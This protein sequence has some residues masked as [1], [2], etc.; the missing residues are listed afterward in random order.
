M[1]TNKI[2]VTVE[3]DTILFQTMKIAIEN[4]YKRSLNRKS[5]SD[6]VRIA[7]AEKVLNDCED[8]DD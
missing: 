8:K 2:R 3:F 7:V 1:T 5:I 4:D 6:Y